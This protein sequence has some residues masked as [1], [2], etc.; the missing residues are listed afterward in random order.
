MSEPNRILILSAL[1][2]P[3]DLG[4]AEVSS[5]NV[6]RWLTERGH[7]VGVLTTAPTRA[8]EVWGGDD[9]GV[10]LFRVFMPRGYT[11]FDTT[12]KRL[13]AKA[14]WHLRDHFDPLNARLARR[15]L[16]EFQPDLVNVKIIQGLGYNMLGV[17]GRAG[18]P[19]VYSLHDLGLVCINMSQFRGGRACAGHC[20]SCRASTAVKSAELARIERLTF[21]SPSRAN[22]STVA[23]LGAI[24]DRPAFAIPNPNR[25]PVPHGP[26]APSDRLQLLFVGRLHASKGL[27]TVVEALYP[28]AAA[29]RVEL[30]VL[31]GGPQE[32]EWRARYRG[33]PW[34][35]FDGQVAVEAVA[36]A[37]HRADALLVPSVWQENSPGVVLHAQAIGLPVIASRVGGIPELVREGEDALL[38]PPGDVEAWRRTFTALLADPAPLARLRA[39]TIAA[40]PSRDPTHRACQMLDVFRATADPGRTTPPVAAEEAI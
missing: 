8:D 29:G 30:A 11:M 26:R 10:T 6:A 3:F 33:L 19:V 17:F 1:Y 23:A 21:I 20:M 36:I 39:G 9:H 25:Y 12:P 18:M 27:E 40:I 7:Q 2:P 22:L 32:A 38:L 35:R 34:L 31:G 14:R 16:A 15:V 13:S 5:H 28:L 4:G 24:G 37:M